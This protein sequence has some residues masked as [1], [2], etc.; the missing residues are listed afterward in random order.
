MKDS[1]FVALDESPDALGITVFS[2]ELREQ[3]YLNRQQAYLRALENTVG[4]K[5]GILSQVEAVDRTAAVVCPII[6]AG[7]VT[8]AVCLMYTEGHDAPGEGDVRL[9]QVAAAF[10]GKQMEE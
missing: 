5:R 3:S 2:P 10:L 8:G 7:D 9:A 6:A 1:L 4:L